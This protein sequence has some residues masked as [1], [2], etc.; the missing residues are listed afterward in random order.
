VPVVTQAPPPPKPAM[1]RPELLPATNTLEGERARL[2]L[3]EQALAEVTAASEAAKGE[4]D[5]LERR[6]AAVGQA[7]RQGEFGAKQRQF[8][9]LEDRLRGLKLK[10]TMCRQNIQRLGGAPSP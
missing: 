10:I 6:I 1:P 5:K 9:M 3:L 4:F 7:G 2:A 8:R